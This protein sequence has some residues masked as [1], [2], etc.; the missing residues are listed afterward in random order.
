MPDNGTFPPP[1]Q[2]PSTARE[3]PTLAFQR[4]VGSDRF[5]DAR[6]E[7]QWAGSAE[8]DSDDEGAHSGPTVSTSLGID[9]A[10]ELMVMQKQYS[11][12]PP[13]LDTWEP[14]CRTAGDTTCS[15]AG[16]WLRDAAPA[17]LL[18]RPPFVKAIDRFDARHGAHKGRAERVLHALAID[19]ESVSKAE[20]FD[21]ACYNLRA[22]KFV[23]PQK[24]LKRARKLTNKSKRA[25]ADVAPQWKLETSI[26]KGRP[27][28]C[29]SKNFYDTE[30][31]ERLK[32][33]L[34]WARAL[35]C[36]LEKV[37]L[38]ADDDDAVDDDGDGII[39]EI[40]EVHEVL[41]QHRRLYFTLFDYYAGFGGDGDLSMSINEWTAFVD[42]CQLA[43]PKSKFCKRADLDRLFINVDGVSSAAQGK[44]AR[45][46][47]LGRT[48]FLNCLVRLAVFKYVLTGQILDVSEACDK[49]FVA[50]IQPRLHPAIA[51]HPDEFRRLY[52]YRKEMDDVLRQH[53]GSTRAI[54]HTIS[55]E[56]KKPSLKSLGEL[57]SLVDWKT[58]AR[59]LGLI[60]SDLT[61]RDAAICFVNSRMAVIDGESERGKAKENHLP[62]EGFL[63]CLCR[64]AILKALPTDS[65][66]EKE[67]CV[68]AGLFMLRLRS[69]QQKHRTYLETNATGWNST[70][71][72][73]HWRCLHHLLAC[74]IRTIEDHVDSGKGGKGHASDMA[75]TKEEMK[76]WAG[77][78]KEHAAKAPD[79]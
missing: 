63:E 6:E 64:V 47:S 9:A 62:Y 11:T 31:V 27:P 74:M 5:V 55:K 20:A 1:S 15:Q 46:N 50:E 37:I 28:W 10:A 48:E 65:E 52:F 60:D 3:R 16:G 41:F 12:A 45:D 38:K 67:E 78:F 34:D 40:E 71:R 59:R 69:N 17:S 23:P 25:P 77:L 73:P 21:E 29:D 18:A 26:W 79:L 75:V 53:E 51:S 54:F 57:L 24:R 44:R 32:M 2:P 14:R 8:D 30:T 68:D 19:V 58:F 66:L 43:D 39:D 35:K 4:I 56:S 72:Q 13:V 7:A 36:G 33:N 42:D 70:P 22:V 49:L 76:S 61:D